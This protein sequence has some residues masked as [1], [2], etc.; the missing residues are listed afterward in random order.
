MNSE[1]DRNIK[2]NVGR[3]DEDV[4]KT[5]SYAYTAEKLSSKLANRRISEGIWSSYDFQNKKV[6][7]IGCGDGTYTLEFPNQGVAEIIGVDPAIAAVDA[8]TKKAA[9]A[10]VSNKVK[11][12]VGN[13]YELAQKYNGC[14]FDCII[15]RGVLHHLPDPERA[16]LAISGISKTLIILEPNGYNPVLKLL[17]RYSRYHIEHEER[18]FLPST[19]RKWI[20]LAG[21]STENVEH[22]NLVPMFC[23][24][25]MAKFC[26]FLQPVVERIPLLREIACGQCVVV[27]RKR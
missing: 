22:I 19:I 6:L 13:I 18:S 1:A 20:A 23:P 27:A 3:F 7:D 8:A 21:M 15:L 24:D 25:W 5:G 10:G 14:A 9:I 16:I 12:D 17:E 4:R 26:N 11:F 2:D